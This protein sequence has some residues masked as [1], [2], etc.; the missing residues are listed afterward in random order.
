M[1]YFS[2]TDAKQFRKL[3]LGYTSGP[4]LGGE[5]DLK[6]F[7][8]VEE[9]VFTNHRITSFKNYY[10][11]QLTSLQLFGNEIK[12]HLPVFSEKL[13]TLELNNPNIAYGNSF[14]GRLTE[15]INKSTNLVTVNIS[16]LDNATVN[17]GIFGSLP[18]FKNYTSL[19]T[20]NLRNCSRIGGEVP[21]L[22]DNTALVT[23]DISGTNV[24]RLANDFAVPSSGTALTTFSV[25]KTSLSDESMNRLVEAIYAKWGSLGSTSGNGKTLELGPVG[26]LTTA[27]FNKLSTLRSKGWTITTS[28]EP[29]AAL[30]DRPFLSAAVALS[31]RKLKSTA[32]RVMRV[33][34]TTDDRHATVVFDENGKTSLSSELTNVQVFSGENTTT[35][36]NTY[37]T[38]SDLALEVQSPFDTPIVASS[39]NSFS[40][41]PTITTNTD[42]SYNIIA[43]ASSSAGANGARIISNLK[44]TFNSGAV[45]SEDDSYRTRI[46]I[47]GTVV[48]KGAGDISI[49][50]RNSTNSNGGGSFFAV[51]PSNP[52]ATLGML[53]TSTGAFSFE[54]FGNNDVTSANTTLGGIEVQLD[55]N[56]TVT[57]Q[58]L[59]IEFI[60]H[61]CTVQTWYDQS[62][63]LVDVT[64]TTHDEQPSIVEDG[65]VLSGGL[66]FGFE[67]DAGGV[68]GDQLLSTAGAYQLGDHDSAFSSMAVVTPH[69]SSAAEGY[70]AGTATDLGSGRGSSLYIDVGSPTSNLDAVLSNGSGIAANESEELTNIGSTSSVN[71]QMVISTVYNDQAVTIHKNKVGTAT[72]TGTYDFSAN[73]SSDKFVLGNRNNSANTV[74]G[75]VYKGDIQEVIFFDGDQSGALETVETNAIEAFNI[76]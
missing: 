47:S 16:S 10:A 6:D 55:T 68:H 22:V 60:K 46:R 45:L 29:A 50:L 41:T 1:P 61:R 66:R 58:N 30:L 72:N 51:N 23:F 44:S 8:N 64:N 4:I 12:N 35:V 49:T 37:K 36:A 7:T 53:L 74:A 69:N 17:H 9:V 34:R 21:T 38:L 31:T 56:Q 33:R 25:N 54:V 65:A 42:G 75:T 13:I 27:N 2:L 73:T 20:L 19:Q 63:N 39:Y 52:T 59:K 71:S 32:T 15:S 14:E 76:T 48:A 28:L 40:G 5:V 24:K 11:G 18:E 43:S 70:I 62:S 67:T 57:I 3:S 26:G